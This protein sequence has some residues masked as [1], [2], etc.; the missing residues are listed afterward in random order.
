MT[1]NT[2]IT[3]HPERAKRGGTSAKW[4][5][6]G[7]MHLKKPSPPWGEGWV[8]GMWSR[9]KRGLYMPPARRFASTSPHRGEG[10]FVRPVTA[11][12]LLL[13][14]F[15]LLPPSPARA[16]CTGPAGIAGQLIY[17]QNSH[18]PQYCTGT[19]WRALATEA[20]DGGAGG[21]TGPSA[22]EGTMVYNDD[23]RTLQYCEGDEWIAIGSCS[24][25][26]G[27]MVG[28]WK[29]DET[30][31]TSAADSSGN[32]NGGT[33]TNMT[34]TE[35][36]R[37]ISGGA[38]ELDG[39]EDYVLVPGQFNA[40]P[41][42]ASA[43]FKANSF[44]TTEGNYL[45]SQR[46]TGLPVRSWAVQILPPTMLG[47]FAVKDA[48][49]SQ[50]AIQSNAPVTTGAWHHIAAVLDETYNLR[51][52]LDGELQDETDNSASL[53]DANL[54]LYIG[55][56][57]NMHYF[58]GLIDDARFYDRA[59]NPLEIQALY[60][61]GVNRNLYDGIV[62][63]FPLDESS[64]ITTLDPVGGSVG[65]LTNGPVWRPG[66]GP[67]GG[68]LEF[69]SSNDAVNV[70]VPD[71]LD[72]I[73]EAP[74][75][76]SVWVYPRSQGGNN[77]GWIVGKA[78]T[79]DVEDGWALRYN[80]FSS[81]EY[82][83]F[84]VNYG[85]Q[86]TQNDDLRVRLVDPWRPQINEW[87]HVVVTWDGTGEADNVR[88]YINGSEPDAYGSRLDGS[89][90]PPD[91]SAL[92]LTIGNTDITLPI[93]AFDGMIDDL[94]IYDRILGEDEAKR[95]FERG[96]NP[97][98]GL[99][100]HWRLDDGA[101]STT[102][103]DSSGNG[104]TGTL[105]NM[106]AA[107]DWVQAA[108]ISGGLDFDGTDDHVS[109]AD[110]PALDLTSTVSVSAWIKADSL[111]TGTEENRIVFKGGGGHGDNLYTLEVNNGII[112]F[113][114]HGFAP[115]VDSSACVATDDFCVRGVTTV[116]TG[117]WY[118]VAG[119]YDGNV[120]KVYVN[121]VED[122]SNIFT[123]TGTANS[124]PL[125]I[126]GR[127][128]A[129]DMFDG[130]IDDVRVHDRALT[131]HEI[132]TLYEQG[133]DLLDGLIGHWPMDE[134]SGTTAADATSYGNDGTLDSDAAFTSG[135]LG[136]AVLL[137]GNDDSVNIANESHFDFERTD[138]FSISAWIYRETDTSEDDIVEKFTPNVGYYVFLNG[139]DDRI[140][141]GLRDGGY[142][143]QEV[144]GTVTLNQWHLVTVTY[145][146]SSDA[147]GLRLFLD[148]S[149][150]STDLTSNNFTSGS[151]LNDSP[152]AIG[153]ESPSESCCG[154][155]GKL[156]DVRIYDRELSPAE[157][158]KLYNSTVDQH[159]CK[160]PGVLAY[161]DTY[162]LMQVCD[163]VNW[164][165]LG[166]CTPVGG[167]LVMHLE[168][169]ETSGTTAGDSTA[170]GNNG[171]LNDF[172][173]DP[174]LDSG[175][176][177]S[178]ALE[179]DGNDDR[180]SIPDDDTLD[181]GTGDFSVSLWIKGDGIP[182]NERVLFQGDTVTTTGFTI[183]LQTQARFYV[184]TTGWGDQGTGVFSTTTVDD[185]SWHHVV[186]VRRNGTNYIYVDGN[187][188]DS[189]SG[190]TA[191]VTNAA[192]I[193]LGDNVWGSAPFTG[194]VDDV[195]IYNR[196]L[197]SAEI[198]TLWM[199]GNMP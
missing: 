73:A 24:D 68:T 181:F 177:F 134:T 55:N 192:T 182:A 175:G 197:T 174:W 84:H 124:Y 100:G 29:F 36:S 111:T 39:I 51:L 196:A 137:D 163:G 19:E 110:N 17:N 85:D 199:L 70:V 22:V 180:V 188:E 130:Q 72:N 10:P 35:W 185:G 156:D 77:Q 67:V 23:Y 152:L 14:A 81:T 52:Y 89:G 83:Q 1:A 107:Q 9:A 118:H 6:N 21:C 115:G 179:F 164:V 149:E 80:Y 15:C 92:D 90:S 121:G 34:G 167:G 28:H 108:T 40:A 136:N 66:S 154:F 125:N 20:G 155:D 13:F 45:F 101:G 105:T 139:S 27:G 94:R 129:S 160:E 44:T 126:G 95:L 135:K 170:L 59:L 119:T 32:G 63:H 190:S 184:W 114:L 113:A 60:E 18:V 75:S 183:H 93:R 88:F 151:M 159:R 145:D 189:A 82:F 120:A 127:S 41:F 33:L 97:D 62:A 37:G 71:S 38:L 3:R 56:D 102:A 116:S 123:N 7:M 194:S 122:G 25:Y 53:L 109:V 132:E 117:T 50:T 176:V 16:D 173:A 171:T 12:F 64:G 153:N 148:G 99:V 104:H 74:G 46:R 79:A 147:S 138:P 49:G 131:S 86:L 31:G 128:D 141:A 5:A 61:D 157:V 48:L 178:G 169:D 65:T 11:L 166:D 57:K 112:A 142:F 158:E 30:S 4:S 161:N 47:H 144:G 193:Y 87:T 26:K 98:D 2:E 103:A 58:D 140:Y 165:A 195:R 162:N 172:P 106:E 186:G 8:R 69:D 146:G 198:E 54:D 168:L 133:L 96:I 187:L 143:L 76:I 42:T 78:D 191:N 150:Q 91:D 43:W